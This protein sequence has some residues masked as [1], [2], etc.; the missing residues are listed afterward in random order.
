MSKFKSNYDLKTQ[1]ALSDVN[2][3]NLKFQKKPRASQEIKKMS[4][5]GELPFKMKK[6]GKSD[7]L[8]SHLVEDKLLEE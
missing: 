7:Y 1:S 6:A 3:G 2:V 8:N 5:V 4:F